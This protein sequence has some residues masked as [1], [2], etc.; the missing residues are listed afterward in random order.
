[1][2]GAWT[3]WIHWHVGICWKSLRT[4]TKKD[5]HWLQVSFRSPP[6][7]TSFRTPR[8]LTRSWT[9][10]SIPHTGSIYP[11]LRVEP[12]KRRKGVLLC[13]DLWY[14]FLIALGCPHSAGFDC[15][16]N[17]GM[18]CLTNSRY[19]VLIEPEYSAAL[20]SALQDK[21]LSG[22]IIATPPS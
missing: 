19:P 14:F 12:S 13:L 9:D 10:S 16:N 20:T 18:G 3:H 1:M 17:A 5:L 4:D 2:T 15:L 7:M 21:F 22:I 8:S 6:G 11:A